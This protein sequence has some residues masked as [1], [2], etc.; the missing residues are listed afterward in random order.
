M[1]RGSDNSAF[2]GALSLSIALLAAATLPRSAMSAEYEGEPLAEIDYADVNDPE[3]ALKGY[4]SEPGDMA[5]KDGLVPAVVIL[6]DW[7]NVNG[8]EMTRADMISKELGYAAFTADIYG[9]D[10]HD[11]QDMPVKVEQATKYRSD[12]A[13]FNSRI[14][15]AIETVKRQP[16]VDPDRVAIIGY[17]LGGTGVIGYSFANNDANDADSDIV[18]AVSFHGGLMEFP[19]EGEMRNPLL[20]LSGGNDDAG[21]AVEDLEATLKAANATWQTTRYS[22]VVHGFTKFGSDAYDEWVDG[23]SWMEMSSFLKEAFG[24]TEYGTPEPADGTDYVVVD[25]SGGDEDEAEVATTTTAVARAAD[26]DGSMVTVQTVSYDDDGFPLE[27]YLA[28]PP[29]LEDGETRPAL[30]ILPDWDG[31]NGPTGYEAGRAVLAAEEAGY[32]AMVADIYGTNYT[33]V[34]DFEARVAQATYYRSDPALFVQRIQ[35]G[36]DEV[37]AHPSVDA[38]SVFVAGYC[39]GGTGSIDYGFSASALENV[40]AVVPLHGGLTPLR[41]VEADA[42]KPYV[43]VLSGGVDDAHGNTTELE[44]H[45]DAHQAKWEISRYSNAEHGFT[46][47]GSGAYQATA[48]SR[49]WDSMMSL[50]K[51]LS[52]DGDD[53]DADQDDHH[54]GDC[55]C[56]GDVPHC[57]DPADEAAYEDECHGD[58]HDHGDMDS[59]DEVMADDSSA[60]GGRF[61]VCAIATAVAA[62]F[63]ALAL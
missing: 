31:V 44:M 38:D 16:G 37:L 7:D 56:D 21:T 35:A 12:F 54:D 36:I 15:S 26:T 3:F 4:M 33:D 11:V 10:M 59:M 14:Q 19:V 42:V 47:W 23:R 39:F 52:D 58:D 46:K 2:R 20:V 1:L 51:T 17:C 24:E 29:G 30:V 60:D 32:V 57:K 48:D 62:L 40:K 49:S 55:H 22:G 5:E 28:V 9:A 27:G 8:Y 13:L 53:H 61:S 45:L 41:A 50:F 34:V 43:L 25:G 18:A 6:P 63:V